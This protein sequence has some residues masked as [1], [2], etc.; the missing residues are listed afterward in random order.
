MARAWLQPEST[1]YTL[2]CIFAAVQ[3][4]DHE[5]THF[6]RNAPGRQG[7]TEEVLT[8]SLSNSNEFQ[9]LNENL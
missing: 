3:V 4:R 5:M 6:L 2:V 7:H 9:A 8:A 1:Q